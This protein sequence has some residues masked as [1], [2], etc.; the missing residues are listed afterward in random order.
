MEDFGYIKN[1][2][3]SQMM[4]KTKK[5]FLIGATLFSVAC[6]VYITINAYS[7]VYKN[8]DKKV[9]TIKSPKNPI[10]V[11]AKDKK[12]EKG[13]MKIDRAIYEDI[14]GSKKEEKIAKQK[15]VRPSPPPKRDRRLIKKQ[16]VLDNETKKNIVVYSENK[17]KKPIKDLLTKK[18]GQSASKTR[19]NKR[20]VR[21]QIA[22]MTS[23][24]SAKEYYRK[25]NRLDSSLFNN[26]EYYIQ[27]V[28]LGKRGIFYR[29]QIGNFFNQIEA[30]KFCE[31]YVVKTNKSRADCI[32]VE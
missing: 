31:K 9:Q 19:P 26:L 5:V 15:I 25:I 17:A 32:I 13:S 28:D 29:L 16:R 30:E 7:F 20:Y 21:V 11:F 4:I 22:A 6:F 24:T 2:E 27:E 1:S 10:K 3:Q 8:K 23:K 18:T 14:F 12:R